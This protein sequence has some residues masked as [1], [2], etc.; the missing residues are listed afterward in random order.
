MFASLAADGRPVGVHVVLSSDQRAG[1]TTALASAVQARMVLRLASED[2]YGM[3]NVAAD[4]L[5]SGSPAGR[6]IFG[7]AETQIAVL[8]G[9][10]DI[11]DQAI[12]IKGFAESMKRAGASIAPPIES[13]PEKVIVSELPDSALGLPVVGLSSDTLGPFVIEPHGTFIVSGSPGSGR[14]TTLLTL[15]QALRTWDP[16]SRLYYFGVSRSPLASL[17]VWQAMALD[18][19]GIADLAATL[20]SELAATTSDTSPVTVVIEGVGELAGGVT[21]DPLEALIKVCI[22][23]EHFVIVEGETSTLS[24]SYGVLGAA[25]TSR[26]G[27]ALA[28][29]QS[30][31]NMVYRT[32]F[33]RLKRSEFPPGRA[34]HVALGR[35]EVVQIGYPDLLAP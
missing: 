2:D 34:L 27:L 33:P 15:I 29:D 26:V 25:K 10:S 4:V 11:V 7:D 3:L 14:T 17:D 1:M 22:A 30:D 23:E 9:T 21:D 35:T 16:A 19:S 13:L 8:G 32:D 20:A 28:P 18:P 6:G 24:G 5:S 31:G 12:A